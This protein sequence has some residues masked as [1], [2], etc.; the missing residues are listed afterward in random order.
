MLMIKLCML[1]S[2]D[3]VSLVEVGSET[4]EMENGFTYL[5]QI[6]QITCEVKCQIA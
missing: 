5:A 2:E 4:I 1:L 6:C 3:D